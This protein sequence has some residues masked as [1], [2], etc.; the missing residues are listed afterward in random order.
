MN[1][2]KPIYKGGWQFGDTIRQELKGPIG[3]G[4]V[5]YPNGDRFKGYFHLSYASINGPAYAADGCYDFADGSYIEKA[6]I[7]T[8]SGQTIFDLHGVFRIHHPEGYDSIAMFFKNKRIGFELVLAEKPYAIEWYAGDRQGDREIESYD[9]AQ[10]DENC[11][12]LTLVLKDGT[13]IVQKGG[14][15]TSNSYNEQIYEPHTDIIVYLPNGD[16]IDMWNWG[17]KSMK[18]YNGYFTVHC[19]ETQRFREEHWENGNL[20][21]ADDWKRDSRAAKYLTLPEPFGKGENKALVWQDGHIVYF[22]CG[23]AYDGELKDD[24]PEGHGVLTSETFQNEGQHYEGEFHE[25]LAHGQG[26]FENTK[27]G[28]R[29]E[30]TFVKGIYQEPKAATAPVILHARHGHSSWSISRQGEWKYEEKDFEAKLDRL[31]FT[32]FGDINIARIENDC[33]TLTDYS[34]NVKE[35]HPGE[36]VH[37]TAEIEGREWSDGCV[38]D[39]DDYSLALTW[40]EELPKHTQ[41]PME[42]TFEITHDREFLKHFLTRWRTLSISP[43]MVERLKNSD[44]YYACYGYG[45]WLY[46]ANPDGNSIKEA[47]E[48]LTLAANYGYVADAFAALAEMHYIG[49]V[50]EDKADYQL[51]AFLMYKAAQEKSELAQYQELYGIIYGEL[52]FKEDPEEAADILKKHLDKHPDSDPIYWDLLGEAVDKTDKD[53]AV[54]YFKKS[55]E[56]GNPESYYSLAIYYY[57]KGD[58]QLFRHY[59]EEGMAKGAVNCH[60]TLASFLTQDDFMALTEEKQKEAHEEIDRGLRYA[61]ERNDRFACYVMAISLYNGELGYEA[62]PAEAMRMAKRGCELGHGQC[63]ELLAQ[64]HEITE[65]IPDELRISQKEIAKLYLQALRHGSSSDAALESVACAYV[66]NLLPNHNKEIEDLWLRKYYDQCIANDENPDATGVLKVY[67]QG[68]FYAAEV[69]QDEFDSLADLAELIDADGVDIVHYSEPLNRMSKVLCIGGHSG[70]HIAMAVD[71]DGYAKDLPDNMAGTILYGHGWEVRGTVMLLLEDEKYNLKPIKGL[72]FFSKCIH[73]LNA[74]TGGLTR[75]PTDDELSALEPPTDDAFEEYDDP[76]FL[77]D[78]E[79][80]E[81]LEQ[82]EE[83]EEVAPVEDDEDAEPKNITVK[84]ADIKEAL[85]QCNLC[86]DTITALLPHSPDYWFKSTDELMYP[87]KDAVEK[88]IERHG[89]YMIDEWQ[90]VYG[91]QPPRDIRY[92]VRFQTESKDDE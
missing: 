14:R 11:L 9:I 7:N 46:Y 86:R 29:Q 25:G 27:A 65:D 50:A 78:I 32:G 28:I 1:D 36:T 39:G 92:L 83:Q 69:E 85:A 16:S 56:M 53:E 31:P 66:Q 5:T 88:N 70:C 54:K 18:P 37:Y 48:K 43:E 24:R 71:R 51:S 42:T 6:W 4:E 12:T 34:N 8:S 62:D 2:N 13:R 76:S 38:Y 67:P 61:V 84:L 23:W 63:F 21:K 64:L 73:M 68:Y 90:Y 87:I 47:Q 57:D 40:K 58:Q 80:D 91:Q 74:A 41:S 44:D 72:L 81:L 79:E 35:L 77:D 89:G 20:T 19:A 45:R 75:Y 17:L 3:D 15:Y 52:G 22:N 49:A 60:R 82:E 10:I 55:V 30:G 59:T 26:V 33:I